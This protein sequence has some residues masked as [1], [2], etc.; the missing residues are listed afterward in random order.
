MT[1]LVELPVAQ[2]LQVR[3]MLSLK[4]SEALQWLVIELYICANLDNFLPAISSS[5]ASFLLHGNNV[6]LLLCYK[7]S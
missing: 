6:V 2:S 4:L 3:L 1:P 7:Y 5:V